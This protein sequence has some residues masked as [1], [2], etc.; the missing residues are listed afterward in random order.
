MSAEQENELNSVPADRQLKTA[1]QSSTPQHIAIIMDGNGRW[2][3]QRGLPRVEGH[4][5]GVESV[6][7]AVKSAIE[8]KIPHLTLYSFS[9]ENWSRPQDEILDLMGLLKRFIQRDL[10]NLHEQ[11]IRVKVIGDWRAVD[12]EIVD[13]IANAQELTKDNTGLKLTVAF[14]YGARDELTRAIK[15]IAHAAQAGDVEPDA[16][17]IDYISSQL[18]TAGEP[19][20]DL[21]IRTSGEIRLSNFL[22]WQCA[23]TEFVFVDTYWPDFDREDFAAALDEYNKRERRYG[24]VS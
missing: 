15:K 9:S 19:D 17:T 6:R 11:N 8:F 10:A 18:D 21:L 1:Q 2:A 24:G 12:G 20:P 23:Y 16:I 7:R 5:Q 4:R 14:N 13:L 22:L 3:A